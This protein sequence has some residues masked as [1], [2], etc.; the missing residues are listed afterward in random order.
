MFHNY[1]MTCCHRH[2]FNLV[3]PTPPHLLTPQCSSSNASCIIHGS[4]SISHS[5]WNIHEPSSFPGPRP[6]KEPSPEQNAERKGRVCD[7][8]DCVQDQWT[9][10]CMSSCSIFF[11]FFKIKK[12][13]QRQKTDWVFGDGGQEEKKRHSHADL[14]RVLCGYRREEKGMTE[15]KKK[16]KEGNR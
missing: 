6:L 12:R 14:A 4:K 3:P 1:E 15:S 10:L 7:V 16:R 2:L 13:E 5:V 8:C 9:R 11:L